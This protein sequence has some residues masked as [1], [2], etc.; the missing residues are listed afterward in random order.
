MRRRNTVCVNTEQLFLKRR[1]AVRNL[2]PR[3]APGSD[4]ESRTTDSDKD[5]NRKTRTTSDTDNSIKKPSLFDDHSRKSLPAKPKKVPAKPKAKPPVKKQPTKNVDISATEPES[6]ESDWSSRT[7]R[8]RPTRNDDQ[9]RVIKIILENISPND[10]PPDKSN[11][12]K[13]RKAPTQES[14]PTNSDIPETTTTDIESSPSPIKKKKKTKKKSI[15]AN[16]LIN[17]N[18]DMHC[19]NPE[20]VKKCLLCGFVGHQLVSHYT[21]QHAGAENYISRLDPTLADQIHKNTTLPYKICRMKGKPVRITKKCIFCNKEKTF[22]RCAWINHLTLHTGE[23]RFYCIKCNYRTSQPK[24]TYTNTSCSGVHSVS[25]MEVPHHDLLDVNCY[26]CNL[27]NYAQLDETKIINH[28]KNQHFQK[29][30]NNKYTKMVV[31]DFRPESLDKRK[32]SKKKKSKSLKVVV[33][34]IV[35]SEEN[36]QTV[37]DEQD[38]KNSSSDIE[39]PVLTPEVLPKRTSLR[40]T[41]NSLSSSYNSNA[42]ISRPKDDDGLFDDDTMRMMND[43]SF[44]MNTTEPVTPKRQASI[45]D[46]LNERFKS[47]QKDEV[48]EIHTKELKKNLDFDTIGTVS[49]SIDGPKS[50]EANLIAQLKTIPQLLDAT[51]IIEH[52][53]PGDD[54]MVTPKTVTGIEKLNDYDDSITEC[55]FEMQCF[56]SDSGTLGKY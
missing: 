18:K 39:M 25:V 34:D 2:R 43:M 45:A 14:T 38:I 35:K 26:V 13:K 27:C 56:K 5:K 50:P 9:N 11:V 53:P 46:K 28:I 48:Q 24:T 12:S 17:T 55:S 49:C 19:L 40:S 44:N 30:P 15:D 36:N 33:D 4:D 22:N 31:V 47:A 21:N 3:N 10:L 52:K 6:S 8:I 29:T 32:N 37:N 16:V 42:F 41:A 51:I 1:E 23:F 20:F 7:L 54:T